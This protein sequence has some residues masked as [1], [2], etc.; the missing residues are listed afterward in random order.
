MKSPNEI[1]NESLDEISKVNTINDITVKI[2]EITDAL[3]KKEL[4]NWT[5][6]QISRAI[7]SLAILR[8]NLGQDMVNA[9]AYYDISY[10]NRKLTYASEWKPTKAKLNAQMN[11]ATV[12]DIDSEI[13]QGI[14]E[15]QENEIKAKHYA[16]QLKVLYDST[17]TLIMAMQSRLNLLKQERFESRSQT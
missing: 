13:T 16:E 4:S 8:V 9:S 14:A 11:K 15:K 2:K 3:Y 12:Q 17:E 1:Y 10:I 7:T 6:D 5:G